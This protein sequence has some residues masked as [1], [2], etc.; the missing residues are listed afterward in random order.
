[1]F[2]KLVPTSSMGVKTTFGKFT[3]LSQPG[4]NLKIPF[5][6]DI[7]LVSN[8]LIQN[9]FKFTVK[10][11][12]NIFSDV[13]IAIQHKVKPENTELAFYS[14][15]KPTGQIKSYTENMLLSMISKITLTELFDSQSIIG[16][17][18]ANNLSVKMEKCGFTIENLLVTAII[19]EKKIQDALNNIEAAKRAKEA[20]KEEAEANYIRQI[21]EA[22]GERDKNI[23]RG[24]G[25]AGQRTAI[26]K[27]YEENVGL[28]SSKLKI[29]PEEIAQF[30]LNIQHL[31]AIEKIGTSNNAKTIFF[32]HDVKDLKKQIMQGRE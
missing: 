28:L 6:Q 32:E 22:E 1:M 7:H 14:L 9:E 15:D 12:D 25:I 20:A 23:L 13:T 19:P 5:I 2:F 17:D 31:E 10:T 30:V 4:F 8:R 29:S 27:G 11:K 18:I 26:L 3:S 16:N 24:Q 21:R